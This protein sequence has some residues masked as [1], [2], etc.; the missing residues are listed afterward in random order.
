MRPTSTSRSRLSGSSTSVDIHEVS[1]EQ[2]DAIRS[3]FDTPD[4]R[5]SIGN[6]LLTTKTLERLEEIASHP[7]EGDEETRVRGSRRRRGA[8]SGEGDAEDAGADEAIADE[9]TAAER[10]DTTTAEEGTLE[11][12]APEATTEDSIL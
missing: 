9:V 11:A 3:I 4:N 5:A 6:Q 1:D 7:E 2:A 10:P 12:E 8:R